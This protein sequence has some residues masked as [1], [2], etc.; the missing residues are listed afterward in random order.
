M[1]AHW[2][3]SLLLTVV[4]QNFVGGASQKYMAWN[5]VNVT[6]IVNA[7]Q[8]SCVSF[9]F[10]QN[11]VSVK[12]HR[13]HNSHTELYVVCWERLLCSWEYALCLVRGQEADGCC[14]ILGS[15]GHYRE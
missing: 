5:T 11:T 9:S 2:K 10:A 12:M 7:E 3:D 1:S 8:T 13:K 6:F 4:N 15:H 14:P